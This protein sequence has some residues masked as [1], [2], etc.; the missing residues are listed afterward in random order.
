MNVVNDDKAIDPNK[1]AIALSEVEPRI[2]WQVLRFAGNFLVLT[3]NLGKS[4]G[5]TVPS[6]WF[7]TRT[8]IYEIAEMVRSVHT[9]L[10]AKSSAG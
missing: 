2:E 5:I 6:K 4:F 3:K 8:G 7:E 10:V 1:L 9:N